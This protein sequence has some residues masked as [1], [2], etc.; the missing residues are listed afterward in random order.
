MSLSSKSKRQLYRKAVIALLAIL[1]Q[2][3]CN[4]GGSSAGEEG[5]NKPEEVTVQTTVAQV[6]PMDTTVSAQGTLAAGQGASARVAS[7]VLGRLSAVNVREGDR[8]V[9]GQV[10]AIV[11]NRPVQAQSRS[12]QA[13]VA[14]AD[15]QAQGADLAAR[16]AA[17]DQENSVRLA[18][19]ALQS[20]RLDR[21]NA[22]KQAQTALQ[23][24]QT[25]LQKIK[26]GAR[27]QEIAQAEQAVRQ[28]KATR[29]RAAT[30]V[31]RVQFLFDK[32]I[33]SQRQLDDAKT[34]FAVAESALE[35]AT[36]Q[37]SLVKAGAR[38]EDIRAAELRVQQAQEMLTQ[39]KTSGDAKV[40]QAAAT[41]RQAKE[42]ALQVAVKQKDAG[43]QHQIAQQK[44]ADLAAA[45]ATAGYAR[46]HAPLS[47]IVVRRAQN[48]GDMADTTN[49]IVEIADT[50]A[51]NL[52]AS[53]PAGEG[54]LLRVGMQA[55]ITSADLPGR[56]F[57]GHVLNVGQVDPQTNLLT[58]RLSV[59]NPQGALKAGT[60]ATA[61][62]ILRTEPHAVVVPKQAIVTKEGKS[63]LFVVGPDSI[64]HQKEIV[65]GPEQEG[66]V[67]IDKGVASG[68]R[69]IRLGQYELSDGAK[70]KEAEPK[71][72]EA[73][74]KEA[75]DKKADDAKRGKP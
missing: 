74:K 12:A 67:E 53:L 49:P 22:V 56:V 8:V 7:P 66:L 73:P 18:N 46:I 68:E 5:E 58:V 32:G 25:D 14:A 40:A 72:S 15:A 52:V 36:Q 62:I 45:Q 21:D 16:A 41:L 50:R 34:A 61:E 63:I 64:A 29:D 47:G 60:F 59:S 23:T 27:P 54:S 2:P 65:V 75:E 70:V 19:L 28:A 31:E 4:R 48:P 38:P 26:A 55:R 1:I 37:A 43:V 11:D 9:A 42:N 20:A 44:R 24:A 30:E 69:V 6:R 71:E 39:A 57:T 51:L 3:G 13:A 35:S 33:D 17:T 10:V